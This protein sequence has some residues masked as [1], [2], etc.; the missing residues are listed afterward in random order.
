MDKRWRSRPV[1]GR[2]V[3][4]GQA[5]SPAAACRAGFRPMLPRVLGIRLDPGVAVVHDEAGGGGDDDGIP[6]RSRLTFDCFCTCS[7]RQDA[8][9]GAL[10]VAISPIRSARDGPRTAAFCSTTRQPRLAKKASR[11]RQVSLARQP[12]KMSRA[13]PKTEK[14]PN[15]LCCC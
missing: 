6:T 13:R 15:S 5:G 1:I 12:G 14:N 11:P 3:A 7:V 4:V 8:S 10:A 2:P 9:A